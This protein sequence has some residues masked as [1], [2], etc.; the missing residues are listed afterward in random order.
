MN[1]PRHNR[2]IGPDALRQW[3]PFEQMPS[4]PDPVPDQVAVPNPELYVLDKKAMHFRDGKTKWALVPHYDEGWKLHLPLTKN[5]DL[6]PPD[7]AVRKRAVIEG[8]RAPLHDG[9]VELFLYLQKRCIPHKFVPTRSL[10]HRTEEDPVQRGK[11]LTIYPAGTQETLDLVARMEKFL[12]SMADR[13]DGAPRAR[14]DKPVG[15]LGIITARYGSLTGDWVLPP[16]KVTAKLGRPAAKTL[17]KWKVLDDREKYK[18]DH[19][20]DIFD[21]GSRGD[22]GWYHHPCSSASRP[23][24]TDCE[25]DY[26]PATRLWRG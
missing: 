26:D 4:L 9:Y 11:F 5:G 13:F 24:R 10:L 17:D 25:T 12:R 1:P 8:E 6:S 20:Q 18:P 19:I 23:Y 16:I 22:P 15:S 14:C 7:L 3:H 2:P 21:K